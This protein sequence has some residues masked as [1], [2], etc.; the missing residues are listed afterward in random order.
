MTVETQSLT[1]TVRRGR[2]HRPAGQPRSSSPRTVSSSTASIRSELL[3]RHLGRGRSL[4][5]AGARTGSRRNVED[6]DAAVDAAVT[7]Q[8]AWG[9][10]TPK[11]RS[12]V[13]LRIAERVEQNTDLLVRLE[14]ANTG[15]P[16][17]VSRD[18][19]A[20]TVD[21]FRFFAGRR[22]PSPPRRPPT[23]PRTTSPSSSASRW[24][25]SGW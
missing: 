11:E 2:Q 23:T 9:R 25:W 6:V 21:T 19:V 10:L 14:S 12:L 7:A 15:K 13:L 3:Q 22:G 18:D 24:A 20:S 16:F 4:L 1:S 8:A 5:G 17:E